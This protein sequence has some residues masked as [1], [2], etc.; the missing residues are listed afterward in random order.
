[1]TKK[2][3]QLGVCRAALAREP[4]RGPGFSFSACFLVDD[5][6][7]PSALT[8]A[9]RRAWRKL[10]QGVKNTNR[11]M[12]VKYC[13]YNYCRCRTLSVKHWRATMAS[14]DDI[15]QDQF[16]NEHSP[17]GCEHFTVSRAGRTTSS[18]LRF[19]AIRQHNARTIQCASHF[20]VACTIQKRVNAGAR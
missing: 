10:S 6:A 17:N 5:D 16:E 19:L 11:Q 4:V 3:F 9:S 14:K 18:A 1:M 13:I 8:G 15:R 2:F 7:T 20:C 12:A